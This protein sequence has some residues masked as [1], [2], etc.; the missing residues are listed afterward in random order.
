MAARATCVIEG[1]APGR[2]M[3]GRRDVRCTPRRV[4]RPAATCAAP[5][6]DSLCDDDRGEGA[7]HGQP[8]EPS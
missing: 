6:R 2:D 1:T 5:G 4:L 8:S 7:T 3:P